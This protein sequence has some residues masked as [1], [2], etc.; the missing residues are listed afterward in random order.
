MYEG[1]AAATLPIAVVCELYIRLLEVRVIGKA[2]KENGRSE[3]CIKKK[4]SKGVEIG[5]IIPGSSQF[6]IPDFDHC[7]G[8]CHSK[9]VGYSGEKKSTEELNFIFTNY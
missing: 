1:F 8:I 9:G 2:T 3:I 4:F 5:M 6:Y 7:E